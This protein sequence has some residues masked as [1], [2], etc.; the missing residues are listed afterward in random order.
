MLRVPP[1]ARPPLPGFLGVGSPPK[2][3]HHIQPNKNTFSGACISTFLGL[4]CLWAL[5]GSSEGLRMKVTIGPFRKEGVL[6]FWAGSVLH[7]NVPR[8]GA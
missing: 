4:F 6:D 1:M 7:L 5:F 3:P 2:H 8:Q